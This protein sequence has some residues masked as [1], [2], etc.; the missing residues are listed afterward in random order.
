MRP[1]GRRN[2]ERTLVIF[3]NMQ[4]LYL[5]TVFLRQQLRQT[6]DL[7]ERAQILSHIRNLEHAASVGTRSVYFELSHS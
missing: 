6:V 2:D 3:P 4:I 1:S 7:Q 5:F